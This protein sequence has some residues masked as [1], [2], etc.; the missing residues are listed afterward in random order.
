PHSLVVN[1]NQQLYI[2]GSSNSANYP[3][4]ANGF[5]RQL[6]ADNFG[7][8]LPHIIVTKLSAN[9]SA[10][11]GS[12]Y[13]G[14]RIESNGNS[15]SSMLRYYGDAFKGEIIID[16]NDNAYVASYTRAPDFPITIGA[17]QTTY[18]GGNQDGVVFKL[19][20]DLSSLLWSTYLGGPGADACY[21]LKLDANGDL[22][23]A[24]AVSSNFLPGTAGAVFPNYQGGLFDAFVAHI[25]ADGQM[26]LKAT[27]FGSVIE[28]QAYLI[29]LDKYGNV[30][31][32]GASPN[33]A[34]QATPGAYQ[35]VMNGTFITKFTPA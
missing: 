6:L 29:D 4:S 35:G 12:T 28:E 34:I 24:G 13:V 18:G 31:I 15:H 1:A 32:F 14:G 3:V 8:L 16:D 5:Q 7:N 2:Y 25:R 27:Y 19:N 33:T 20:S 17:L 21:G 22:F 11:L 9:G 26:M 23:V 10:L 30:Y